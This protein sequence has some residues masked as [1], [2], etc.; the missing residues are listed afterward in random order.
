MGWNLVSKSLNWNG[1]NYPRLFSDWILDTPLFF[2][3]IAAAMICSP[4]GAYYCRL[5]VGGGFI[6]V[7]FLFGFLG[8]TV[9]IYAMA[10]SAA[11]G[12]LFFG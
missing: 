3:V 12:L 9:F 5:A 2:A 6:R 4:I 8:S 11:V 7:S 1:P 10:T